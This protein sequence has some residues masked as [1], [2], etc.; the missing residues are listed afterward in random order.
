MF[1]F[2]RKNLKTEMFSIFYF[3]NICNLEKRNKGEDDFME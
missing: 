3:K 2:D 1:V